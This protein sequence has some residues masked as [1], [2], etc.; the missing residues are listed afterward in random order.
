MPIAPQD[1]YVWLQTTVRRD[2]S[3]TLLSVR[4]S[5]IGE[6]FEVVTDHIDRKFP[7]DYASL[8]TWW[9]NAWGL[10]IEKAKRLGRTHILRL[11]DD[12]LVNEHILHN[13][14]RWSALQSP[15]F[16]IGVLFHPDYWADR[17]ELLRVEPTTGATF[18]S[19][20]DVEGAQGQVLPLSHAQAILNGVPAAL[21]A[22]G[23]KP[24][25]Q[26]SFD[27]SLTRSAASLGLYTYV[28]D[29]ALVNIHEGSLHSK[30]DQTQHITGTSA[31][32]LDHY[33]GNQSFNAH[34]K[35]R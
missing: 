9:Q 31:N 34:W 11:E 7:D 35:A 13:I 20:I 24:T 1:I 8:Q 23:Q 32:P 14:S 33:W 18:R 4:H 27:W 5:D 15:K 12:I 19:V 17:P 26:P 6:N 16:G 29:P 21:A 30:I 25:D 3:K 22:R 10:Q 2:S 28:H